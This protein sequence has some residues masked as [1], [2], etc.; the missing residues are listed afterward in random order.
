[1]LIAYYLSCSINWD[2]VLFCR[3]GIFSRSHRTNHFNVIVHKRNCGHHWKFQKKELWKILS[4]IKAV[5]TLLKT[6]Q[7]NFFGM[8]EINQRLASVHRIQEQQLN[9]QKNTELCCIL[10]S[11]DP[12]C[13]SP[14]PSQ[15]WKTATIKSG[16]PRNWNSFKVPFTEKGQYWLWRLHM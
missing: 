4:S 15:S 2:L 9:L 16:S 14:V 13:L 3:E 7:I 8:L 10:I 5:R 1:M 11:P 6:V 12:I